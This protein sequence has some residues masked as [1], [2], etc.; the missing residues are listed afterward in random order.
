MTVFCP[1]CGTPSV[2]AENRFRPFCS[3]R[4]QMV[5]LGRWVQGD[6]RAPAE[7]VGEDAPTDP[8][9]QPAPER[10]DEP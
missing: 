7:P 5:D 1:I 9:S 4:C 3:E 2:W 6:Y 10:D 8:A